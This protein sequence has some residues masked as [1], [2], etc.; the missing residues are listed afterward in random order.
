MTT[1]RPQLAAD[2][3]PAVGARGYHPNLIALRG[4]KLS[5]V[6]AITRNGDDQVLYVGESHT[7]R[8]Y[9]T[10]TRHFRRWKIPPGVDA[11]GRRRGGTP[12]SR[13]TVRVV[14]LVTPP[15]LAQEIQ[16]AE[17]RRLRPQDNANDGHSAASADIPI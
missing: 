5:G 17:I 16:Y 7:G 1:S 14:Y 3:F 13:F 6:Y 10:I 11:Q 4:K 12:Y 2:T 8:L 9:D 15:G